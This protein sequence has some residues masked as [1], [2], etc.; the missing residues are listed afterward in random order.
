MKKYIEIIAG[1]IKNKNIVPK[2]ASILLAVILWAYISN[3]KS[4]DVR[5]RLP[6][7]YTGLDEKYTVSKVSHKFVMVEVSGNKDDLKNI[8]P[9]N[10]KL[11]ADLSKAVPGELKP[12]TIQYQKIDFTDDLKI[13]LYPEEVKVF[14]EKKIERNV[15]IIP[16][17]TGYPEKGFMTGNLKVNPEY[18]RIAGPLSVIN[19][20]G[21]VYTEN[22]AVDNK[23]SMFRQDVKITPI[24]EDQL[25]Y[26]ISKVNV[27]VPIL[28]L[29]EV[30]SFEIPVTIR[31]KK[32]GL[33]YIFN[34]NRVKVNVMVPDNKNIGEHSFSAYI[35]VDDIEAGDEDFLKKSRIEVM[36]YVYVEGDT[37]ESENV[38]LS[39]V[40][41]VVEIAVTKE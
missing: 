32:K 26:S 5:F 38:I 37:S 7:N 17:Y 22:I 4:G 14:I 31:N 41:E 23:N 40:P 30:T 1:I 3:S 12:V 2:L 35:D 15:K 8:T 39:S 13:S 21:A 34:L 19:N 10:V 36:R 29:S 27:T 20:I 11:V 33:H 16:K 24:N 25:K 18:V 9:K 28:N 6:V